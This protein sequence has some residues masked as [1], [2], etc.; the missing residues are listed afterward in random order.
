MSSGWVLA[1]RRKSA[2]ARAASRSRQQM[3][4]TATNQPFFQMLPY[5]SSSSSGSVSP[6]HQRGSAGDSAAGS[7]GGSAGDSAEGSAGDSAAGSAG[8]SAEGSVG[9]SAG[10]SA[11]DSAAC[12]AGDSAAGS[13]GD[14]SD[15]SAGDSA[16]GSA[17][18]SA[19]E[20]TT[21][22]TSLKSNSLG[23]E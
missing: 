15:G 18:D 13:A 14:S 19:G 16:A 21:A 8:D 7:A 12:S 23:L 22:S 1:S 17:G 9:D 20:F 10:D 6:S 3:L 11:A 4:K 2:K 5:C